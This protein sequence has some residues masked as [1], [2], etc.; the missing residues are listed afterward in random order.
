MCVC[1]CVCVSVCLRVCAYARTMCV[2]VGVYVICNAF[3][4]S[5]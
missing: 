1:V 2:R 3:S 4:V 5:L